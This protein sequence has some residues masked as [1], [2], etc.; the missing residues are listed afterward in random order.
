MAQLLKALTALV[1]NLSSVPG[2]QE[3]QLTAACTPVLGD[4]MSS[5]CLQ[6][7]PHTHVSLTHTHTL[8]YIFPY[9]HEEA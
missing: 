3:G 2:T 7:H 9:I 4:T 1:D 6:G 5:S 8:K